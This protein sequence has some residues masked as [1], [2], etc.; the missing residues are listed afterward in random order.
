MSRIVL[1]CEI[2]GIR[3]QKLLLA[4]PWII[5][6]NAQDSRSFVWIRGSEKEFL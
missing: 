4:L 6:W 1:I 5:E 3:G 2:R